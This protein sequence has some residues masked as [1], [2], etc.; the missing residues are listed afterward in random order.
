MGEHAAPGAVEVVFAKAF[1]RHVDC[2]AAWVA[3]ATVGDALHAYFGEHPA[4]RSYVLDEAGAV[5][6]HVAVFVNDDLIADRSTLADPLATG[7]RVHVFQAL[8]GG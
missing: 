1:R 6:R 7:D 4:V 8:S 2:P 3:G 5:R